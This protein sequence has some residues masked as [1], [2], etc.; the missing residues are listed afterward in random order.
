MWSSYPEI[1]IVFKLRLD[2]MWSSTPVFVT[3]DPGKPVMPCGLRYRLLSITLEPFNIF[4]R[5]NVFSPPWFTRS[6][7]PALFPKHLRTLLCPFWTKKSIFVQKG[8]DG[9]KRVPNGQ[10]HLGW[11]FWSILD[12]F[13]LLTSLPCLVQNRPFSGLPQSWTVD[14]KVKNKT[15]AGAS[16]EGSLKKILKGLKH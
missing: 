16:F 1:L 8:L 6:S 14:P 2:V 10:K 3:L 13:G 7:E 5:K 9:P 4:Q 15:V 12:H 11:P